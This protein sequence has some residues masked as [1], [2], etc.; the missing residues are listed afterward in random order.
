MRACTI[1]CRASLSA[2]VFEHG[3][4]VRQSLLRKRGSNNQA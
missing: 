3:L 4:E 1:A 2:H